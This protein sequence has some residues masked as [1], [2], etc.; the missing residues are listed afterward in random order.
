MDKSKENKV[1]RLKKWELV[2][3]DQRCFAVGLELVKGKL[4][5]LIESGSRD[6]V[7]AYM[8]QLAGWEDKEERMRSYNVHRITGTKQDRWMF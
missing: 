3:W 4:N 1:E 8:R 2:Q 7:R 6:M 5:V